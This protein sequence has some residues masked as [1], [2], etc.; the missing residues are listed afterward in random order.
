MKFRTICCKI[1]PVIIWEI[2]ILN[3][4]VLFLGRGNHYY[5]QHDGKVLSSIVLGDD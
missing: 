2:K 4:T 5:N 3:I 1:L